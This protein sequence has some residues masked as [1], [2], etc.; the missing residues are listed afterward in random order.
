MAHALDKLAGPRDSRPTAQQIIQDYKKVNALKGKIIL[1]T[2]V[3]SG[4]GAASAIA[5]AT[6]GATIFTAGRDVPQ[7][8][9]ALASIANSPKVHFLEL[10]LAS[11]AS[12]KSFA[13]K[14]LKQSGGKIH[15]LLNNAGGTLSKRATTED[16]VEKQFAI[17]YLSP[18]LLFS[19][20]KDSLLASATMEFP[21]RVLNLTSIGHR[22]S[23]I[24]F[25]NLNLEG[26]YVGQVAYGQAKTA[27]IYM[28]SE[29]ERRYGSRNLHA[30]SLHP[31]AILESQFIA[32][33]G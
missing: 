6:T 32:N 17:N 9:A 24:R 11:Q 31:G 33:A 10:D 21:S 29:I 13:K 16:G 20:L 5:L 14:F 22:Y 26:D 12:V 3:S 4:L 30:W 19:L 25:D 28:A 7:N 23:G 2:G 27:A 15:I 8:K 18:F 1:I